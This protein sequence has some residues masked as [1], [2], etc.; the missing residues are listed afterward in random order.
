MK[1]EQKLSKCKNSKRLT[2]RRFGNGHK[3]ILPEY[4]PFI[5]QNVASGKTYEE[6]AGAVKDEF[7]VSVTRQAIGALLLRNQEDYRAYLAELKDVRTANAKARLLDMEKVAD[8]LKDRLAEIMGFVPNLWTKLQ[9][10]KL[11]NCYVNLMEQIAVDSGDRRQ[12]DKRSDSAGLNLTQYF[13]DTVINA[14]ADQ[15]IEARA[16]ETPDSRNRIKTLGFLDS[17]DSISDN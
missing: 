10:S 2:D 6:A 1:K 4:Y 15:A 16:K 17:G 3:K 14:F 13:G 8:K 9:L 5:Y 12:G 11:I 7:G